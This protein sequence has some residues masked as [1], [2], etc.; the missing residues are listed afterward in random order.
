MTKPDL[1]EALE[2]FL[3]TQLSCQ[4]EDAVI[5]AVF[6]IYSLNK[7]PVR[8]AAVETIGKY[9]QNI[10]ENPD[11]PK[12]RRIRISNK[13][14]QERVACVKG[15]REFLSAV[16]FEEKM[17]PAKEGAAPESFLVVSERTVN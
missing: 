12:Y 8:E 11:E 6:L 1:M 15:A 17:E 9:L 16:G 7:K 14:F 2:D 5:P 10:I 3:K 4:N 13:V